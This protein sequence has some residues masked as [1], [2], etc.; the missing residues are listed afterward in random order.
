MDH[1]GWG[2]RIDHKSYVYTQNPNPNL[3]IPQEIIV[4]EVSTLYYLNFTLVY[5]VIKGIYYFR[6]NKY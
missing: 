1:A 2:K 6:V 3:T 4:S 5:E